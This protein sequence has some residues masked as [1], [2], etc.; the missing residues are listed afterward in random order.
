MITVSLLIAEPGR[1]S[2]EVGQILFS[3]VPVQSEADYQCNPPRLL[4]FPEARALS[5]E[6]AQ[7]A[8]QGKIGR[9]GWRRVN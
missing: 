7:Q 3:V 6:L 8:S 5:F 1:L 2:M 4:A 9:Y